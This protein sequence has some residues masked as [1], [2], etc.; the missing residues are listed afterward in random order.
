MVVAKLVLFGESSLRRALQQYL[1]HYQ[2][3]VLLAAA[4]TAPQRDWSLRK[5]SPQPAVFRFSREVRTRPN[6]EVSSSSVQASWKSR[7]RVADLRDW[8]DLRLLTVKVNR[9]RQSYRPGLR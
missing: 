1:L 3:E 2:C 8:D 9:L 6:V 4:A 7:D 5:T